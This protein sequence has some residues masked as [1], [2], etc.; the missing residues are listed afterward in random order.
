[1]S[2]ANSGSTS[3][4]NPQTPEVRTLFEC[5]VNVSEGRDHAT[6][7]AL[8]SEGDPTTIDVHSDPHH[9][10]TVLTLAGSR[11]ILGGAI[12]RIAALAVER[13]DIRV[14]SGAHPR[15]GAL[16]VVPFVD[17]SEL[18]WS[19]PSPSPASPPVPGTG[20]CEQR[21]EFARWASERLGLPCFLY[22]DERS[23]P[24]VR[25]SAWRSL[26]P[27]VGPSHPHPTAGAAAVGCRPIL[28]AYNLWLERP[29][30]GAARAV[31]AVIRS[32]R[33][34]A[35][36]LAVG[37]HVQV[38]CNLLRPFEFGP[39]RV[40]DAVE[41]H[42]PVARAEL[43]GLIPRAVLHAEAMSRWEQLALSEESTIEARL[44]QAGLDGGRFAT[45]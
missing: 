26:D 42:L 7:D 22:G 45:D 19:G 17:L 30:L 32:P 21:D 39:G 13:I 14:H 20:A 44:S 23:L 31:A 37:S 33:V 5:V 3:K 4:A 29:D 38:S 11:E 35:L 41:Q 24:E 18:A 40:Y 2:D 43:V 15:L 16:D 1:M 12:R 25:R 34:R 28:V 9:N 36:G 6:I 8:A 27:D 10:R